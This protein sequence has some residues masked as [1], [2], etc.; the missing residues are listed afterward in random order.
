MTDAKL[1]SG[2][3]VQF[4]APAGLLGM[5]SVLPVASARGLDVQYWRAYRAFGSI[6]Y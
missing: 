3:G 6:H 5:P 1:I 4:C 2:P